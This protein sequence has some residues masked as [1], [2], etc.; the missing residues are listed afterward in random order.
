VDTVSEDGVI[1]AGERIA[2]YT[3]I[4][5]AGVS[6]SPAARWLKAESD[7]AGR[8][9]VQNDLTVPGHPGI[10]VVGDTASFA[11]DG[12]PPHSRKPAPGPFRY[13]DKGAMAVVG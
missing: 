2:G 9:R 4:W 8:V 10:F 11:Q 12:K 7:R 13:F 1:V 3:V 5:T 6:P